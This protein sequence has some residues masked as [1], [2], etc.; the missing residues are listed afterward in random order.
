MIFETIRLLLD[1]SGGSCEG[2]HQAV[3]ATISSE[4]AMCLWEDAPWTTTKD[5]ISGRK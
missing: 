2:K 3:L 4:G 1:G 5:W